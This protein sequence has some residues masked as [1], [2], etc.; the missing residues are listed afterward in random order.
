[1]TEPRPTLVLL[2]LWTLWTLATATAW[3]IIPYFGW[4]VKGA[5][6]T[7]WSQIPPLALAYGWSGVALGAVV[8]V[9]QWGVLRVHFRF[10]GR[11]VWATAIGEGLGSPLGFVL[12]TS[13]IAWANPPLLTPKA[14]GLMD[15]APPVELT[16]LFAGLLT[17]VVQWPVLRRV[18]RKE[19]LRRG[20]ALWTLGTGL[21]EIGG[22]FGTR[23]VGG[24]MPLFAQSA[25]VG[26][27][28]GALSGG[29]LVLYLSLS[30]Q[31][32]EENQAPLPQVTS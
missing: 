32:A 25:A 20:M 4:W 24:G 29:I 22:F 6:L 18:V 8:G 28:L 16:I 5:S 7:S 27:V 17:G 3:A 13:A 12:A 23:L 2:R 31:Q 9:A 19:R 30:S 21:G 14:A 26:A 10:P 11:W 15:L 1:M